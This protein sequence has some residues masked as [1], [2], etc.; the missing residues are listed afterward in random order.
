MEQIRNAYESLKKSESSM[1]QII[2]P[3][4][5][6]IIDLAMAYQ[7]LKNAIK[8]IERCLEER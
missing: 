4:D 1:N 7:D 8:H 5:S 3:C 6:R 2:M